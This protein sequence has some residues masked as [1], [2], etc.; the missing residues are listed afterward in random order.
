MSLR[1][2]FK[3]QNKSAVQVKHL[4]SI[5]LVAEAFSK[6]LPE[7]KDC[8]N[9][10]V[11]EKHVSLAVEVLI[12]KNKYFLNKNRSILSANSILRMKELVANRQA[13]YCNLPADFYSC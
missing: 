3:S 5:I 11:K 8:F 13:S 4:C 9:V 1:K 10:I 6:L 7:K 2:T 12:L